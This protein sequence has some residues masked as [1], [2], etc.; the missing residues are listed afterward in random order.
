[1]SRLPEHIH[2]FS[3]NTRISLELPI[4]FEEEQE[5][6][7]SATAIYA[8]DPD[9]DGN[10]I[11]RVMARTVA[12]P[13]GA[14]DDSFRRLAHEA[15]S[16]DGHTVIA[17][18]ELEIDGMPAVRQLLRQYYEESEVIRHE[19][20]AQAANLVFTIIALTSAD[21][22]DDYLSAFDH[23]ADTARFILLP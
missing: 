23:A 22:Q 5:D 1:M 16:M 9:D 4:G 12:L 6:A 2:W 21:R 3:W 8:D 20:Y 15:A 19:T 11:A 17:S 14:P 10:P 13:T 18:H 7:E